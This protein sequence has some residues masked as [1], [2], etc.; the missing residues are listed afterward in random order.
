MSRN[1]SVW[2]AL[3]LL[4]GETCLAQVVSPWDIKDPELRSLQQQYMNDL[5]S[6]GSDILANRFELSLLSQP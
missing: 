6:A 3:F 2:L 1:K 5:Q 4:A